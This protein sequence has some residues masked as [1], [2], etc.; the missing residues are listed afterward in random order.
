M[1]FRADVLKNRRWSINRIM[2]NAWRARLRAEIKKSGKSLR[3]ISLEAGAAHGYVHSLL[4]EDKDPTLSNL[5]AVCRVLG[6]SLPYI[7]YGQ[8]ITPEGEELLNLVADA[9]PSVVQGVIDI[10]RNRKAT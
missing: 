8:Q 6:V 2:S 1:P 9:D 10:L 7:L 5:S 3:S 4:S